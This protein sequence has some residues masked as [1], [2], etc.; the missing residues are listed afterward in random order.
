MAWYRTGSITLTNN[1]DQVSGIGTAWLTQVRPADVLLV[2]GDLF[3]I[4]SVESDTSLTLVANYSGSTAAGLSYAIVPTGLMPAELSRNLSALQQKYLLTMSQLLAWETSTDATVPITNPATGVTANVVPLRLLNFTTGV[5]WHD[6]TGVPAND[7][8]SNGDYYLDVVTGD[9]YKKAA[10]AYSVI[11]NIKGTDGEAAEMGAQG[12]AG[13]AGATGATGDT[14]APGPSYPDLKASFPGALSNMTGKLKYRP[15]VALVLTHINLDVGTA[16]TVDLV[17]DVLKNGSSIFG[18]GAKPKV[19]A[20]E[21]AG[22]LAIG[23]VELTTA[24]VL[25][26]DVISASGRDLVV[27]ID[28]DFLEEA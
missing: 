21:V 17:I 4:E 23:G 20:S 11:A 25:T 13:P 1:S 27:R 15:R 9:V 14:G 12:P 22:S 10:W 2:N 16:P 19:L 6:G 3:E 8:G 18:A 26:L 24:D 28:Y 5:A 7:L